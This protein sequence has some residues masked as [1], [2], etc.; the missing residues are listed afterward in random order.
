MP[1]PAPRPTAPPPRPGRGPPTAPRAPLLMEG[2]GGV[3]AERRSTTP[4]AGAR[5][6]GLATADR[7]LDAATRRACRLDV[8][9][10]TTVA[11]CR[12]AGCGWRT[13]ALD[14][15]DARTLYAQH[16]RATHARSPI[17]RRSTP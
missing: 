6:P 1:E 5:L 9:P 10:G 3:V 11:L 16:F 17:S 4:T 8:S 12:R 2:R 14:P 15:N 7:N 13:V